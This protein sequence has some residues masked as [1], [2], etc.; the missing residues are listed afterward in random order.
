MPKKVYD[1]NNTLFALD[2]GTRSVI[3]LVVEA[4]DRGFKLLAQCMVEHQHRAMLDGQIHDI[5]RVAEAVRQVKNDLEKKL[6]FN[7]KRVAIA[8]AGRSLRTRVCRI[9]QELIEDMEIDAILVNSLEMMGVQQAQ[10]L[11][12]QEINSGDKEKFYCVGHS[13]VGYY[14][15]DYPMANLIGHR[16]KKAAADVLATFLPASVVNGLYAVLSR[17]GLEPFYMTLEPIAACEVVIPEQLR[18]LNLAL[19]DVGAGTSDIAIAKDGAIQAYGMVPTA[20]DEISELIVES[21]MVDFL[22]AEQIKRSLAEGKD[23]KY[24]DILGT[25]MTVSCQEMITFIEPAVE[26]LAREIADHILHLNSKVSPKSV[27]CVGG[28][29]QVPLLTEKLAQHLGLQQQRVAIRNR[30]NI[31]VLQAGKKKDIAGPE[32]VTVVGIIAM[33]AKRMNQNF[34]SITV[35]GQVFSLFNT[36]NLNVL[37]ALALLEYNPRDLIGYNGRDI[38]FI[39]NGKSKTIYGGLAQPAVITLNGKPA[40]VKTPVKDGD[41]LQV[42]KAVNGSDAVAI[43][44]NFLADYPVDSLICLLNGQPVT[45]EKAIN[46][47]DVLEI[48]PAVREPLPDHREKRSFKEAGPG[49][50]PLNPVRVTVNDQ[51]INLEGKQ[52]YI[53]IDIFNYYTVDTSKARGVVQITRNGESAEY[54]DLL[55]DGD[56]IQIQW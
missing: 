26:K 22:T 16:G 51:V 4:Q 41:I 3:G 39:L 38:R 28:G 20:G 12:E 31:T 40:N 21:C 6:K 30:S 5:P 50:K 47:G 18:L 43:V 34:I 56:Q 36:W 52:E 46:S 45:P 55:R 44:G 32:G 1:E 11:L 49:T 25:E 23:I 33:A 53:L 2:I 7:L 8:A 42:V 27:L 14:L 19:V 35:N 24:R 37:N 15:N 9:E 17:V 13:L 29:S 54:T 48:R 10:S